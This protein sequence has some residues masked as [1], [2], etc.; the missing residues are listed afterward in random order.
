MG[1]PREVPRALG[2]ESSLGDTFS[3]SPHVAKNRAAA[4]GDAGLAAGTSQGPHQP[5]SSVLC[6]SGGGTGG[7]LLS[8]ASTSHHPSGSGTPSPGLPTQPWSAGL[9]GP[10]TE[11]RGSACPPQ[12][13]CWPALWERKRKSTTPRWGSHT[14]RSGAPRSQARGPLKG[15]PPR[16]VSTSPPTECGQ[17]GGAPQESEHGLCCCTTP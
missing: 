15:P 1:L 14:H 9:T 5:A 13:I 11:G 4:P 17:A 10:R 6:R 12:Q 2:T 16:P 3:L 8:E 7:S